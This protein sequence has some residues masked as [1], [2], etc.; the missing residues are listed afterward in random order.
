VDIVSF[1]RQIAARQRIHWEKIQMRN[2]TL[3]LAAAAG[4]AVL[5][6][7]TLQ[8]QGGQQAS[9]DV[10]KIEAGKYAADASHSLVGWRVSHLG[11]NDY[12][13]IFGDVA[14]TL[15]LD[16]ANP[17]AAK[18]DVTIPLA[19]V[20]VPS[21]G[22]KDHLLRA[23][24]NGGAADFFGPN[25]TAARFVSTAVQASGKEAKITG[26]LTLNGVTKPVTIDAELSGAGANGMNQKKTVGFHGE[27]TIKRSEFNM[28][29][30]IPFGIGDEVELD[31][32]VAFEKQ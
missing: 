9:V 29:W 14:G 17:S 15:E 30:G 23:G 2:W 19:S 25:P 10:S 24:Q 4:L 31:I 27:T 26:N 18:V 16:P 11:F 32:S 1:A 13:G 6:V 7:G 21:A 12:F 5:S 22:L 28:A 20:V 8:A 3:P